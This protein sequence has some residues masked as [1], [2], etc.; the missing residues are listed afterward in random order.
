MK[1]L[2]EVQRRLRELKPHLFKSEEE[3]QGQVVEEEN[4]DDGGLEIKNKPVDRKKKLK[5][6]EIN[7]KKLKRLHR[8]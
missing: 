1:E 3:Q 5:R 4:D 7:R 2:K 8:E 6:S